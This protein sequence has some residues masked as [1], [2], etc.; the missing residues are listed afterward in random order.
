M[1]KGKITL[2]HNHCCGHSPLS[3]S[4]GKAAD[5]L[6]LVALPVCNQCLQIELSP[7]SRFLRLCRL[8]IVSLT[9]LLLS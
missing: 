5:L 6:L 7:P 4:G 3:F 9:G 2:P 1:Q 8:A